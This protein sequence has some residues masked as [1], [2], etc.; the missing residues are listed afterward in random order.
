MTRKLFATLI[1]GVGAA[2]L[3][4]GA[5]IAT[6]T[7]T[8]PPAPPEHQG[9]PPGPGMMIPGMLPP[10]ALPHIAKRLG[11]SDDQQTRIKEY[12]DQAK[13]GLKQL[14]DQIHTNMELLAK[15]RPDDPAYA[16]VVNNV[17]QAMSEAA[18]QM[19]L[20]GSQLRSQMFGVLSGDQK[21]KLAAMQNQM[22]DWHGPGPHG[23]HDHG[24]GG[25]GP[26]P[27]APH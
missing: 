27:E 13:P 6:Q 1:A 23:H 8:P 22:A 20:Q 19:V 2:A 17:S 9:P 21:T 11:L 10:E 24:N 15:T 25:D 14:H 26:P 12:M 16:T 5:A 3:L 7:D 4:T 18:G